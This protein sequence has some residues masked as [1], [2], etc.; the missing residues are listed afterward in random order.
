MPL[1]KKQVVKA[2]INYLKKKRSLMPQG[3][4]VPSCHESNSM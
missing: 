1:V 4:S 3:F 2:R